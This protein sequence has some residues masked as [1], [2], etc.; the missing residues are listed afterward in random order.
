MYCLTKIN[1]NIS[2]QSSVKFYWSTKN[3]AETEMFEWPRARDN[4][5]RQ[6]S[7]VTAKKALLFLSFLALPVSPNVESC[8]RNIVLTDWPHQSYR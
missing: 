8:L 1:Q 6:K 3:N 2:Q 7:G 5:V 4:V